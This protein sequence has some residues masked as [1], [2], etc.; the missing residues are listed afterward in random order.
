MSGKRPHC[1]ATQLGLVTTDWG[2][3]RRQYIG[4]I[5]DTV[6][7]ARDQVARTVATLA[8]GG[9]TLLASGGTSG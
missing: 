8:G 2:L 7:M 1:M 5:A 3:L 4:Y 6:A 9:R